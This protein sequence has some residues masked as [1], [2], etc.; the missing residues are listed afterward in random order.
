[1]KKKIIIPLPSYDFDPTEVAVSWEIIRNSGH[2]VEFATVDGKRGH[3]DP[4]MIT[5]EGLDP[6]GFIPGLKKIRLMGLI[7][8]ADRSARNAY[9]KLEK[10]PDFLHP[11]RYSDL[12]ADHYD[13]ILLPGGHAPK[14]RQYLEAKPL[15]HLVADFFDTIIDESGNHKPVAAIC[16]GVLLAA[17]S[18]SNRKNTSVLYGKK[19]TA[20]TWKLERSAW[21][22]TRFY[23]RFWD[24]TYYRTYMESSDEPSG[25]WSVESEVKRGLK[26]DDD[27]LDVP[28]N[29]THHF[30][31]TSGMFR[32]RAN[33]TRP[34]WVVQDGNYISARWPGDVHAFAQRFV[35][36][37][38]DPVHGGHSA[39]T[40]R[41]TSVDR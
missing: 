30:L 14:M 19:T 18:I 39:Q 37:L 21:T 28:K 31:K 3:A 35:D 26:T 27:F 41:N 2:D 4:L 11:K 5:G 8:R 38:N 6:W 10:D 33:D 13:A 23:A 15:Q 40:L 34:A 9:H 12:K 1:M 20:L 25:Y 17:R 29:N 36:L 16:H 22:L 32:D 24:P 7:L